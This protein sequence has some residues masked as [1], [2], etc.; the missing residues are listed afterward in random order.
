LPNAGKS[1]LLRAMSAARPKVG[2]YPFTTL[3]PYLGVAERE[4]ERVVVADIPGLIEG[5]HEG[6]GLGATFL[7]HVRRTR[8]LIHVVD[9]TAEDPAV[10]IEVVRR[11]LEAFGQGLSEKRWLLAL[12]K[13]DLLDG[14]AVARAAARLRGRAAPVLAVSALTQRGLPELIDAIFVYVGQARAAEAAVPAP[15]PVLRPAPLR[16]FEVVRAGGGFV[17]RGER[18]V[19]VIA[20]LG[21]DSEETRAEVARRLRRM[22]VTAA[23]RRAGVADGDRVRIGRA[24]LEWPL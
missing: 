17:V 24:E 2:A 5:A 22:G 1:S 18:P 21:V 16:Q 6:L 20:K 7:Q 9:A 19:Q 12:N 8:V 4:Y 3:E 14:E 15:L 10:E 11:E 23:L 13:I